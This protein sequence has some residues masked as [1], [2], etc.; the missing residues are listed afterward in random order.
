MARAEICGVRD[1][2]NASLDNPLGASLCGVLSDSLEKAISKAG[3]SESEAPSMS[4]HLDARTNKKAL[5]KGPYPA[6]VEAF[7]EVL[8]EGNG[9]PVGRWPALKAR[10]AFT[11]CKALCFV[12]VHGVVGLE[13]WIARKFSASH[14]LKRGAVRRRAR[15]LYRESRQRGRVFR[16]DE[17]RDGV[18]G[19]GRRARVRGTAEH[20][21]GGTGA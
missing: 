13:R 14:A 21:L 6:L 5:G 3:I 15:R 1:A 17:H 16:G 10:V 4:L 12:R 19:Q 18:G 2:A 20:S 7:A 9:R 11:L 8:R